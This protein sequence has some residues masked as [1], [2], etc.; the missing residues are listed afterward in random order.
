MSEDIFFWSEADRGKV[1]RVRRGDD[2]RSVP[3][4]D[5]VPREAAAP[6]PE[7]IGRL[8]LR[9]ASAQYGVPVSTLRSWCRRGTI[10][11][12]LVEPGPRWMV[13]PVSVER[14]AANRRGAGAPRARGGAAPGGGMLVPRDAWDR[15]IGQLTNLHETGQ[16]LAEAR[17]RAARAETEAAFLRERLAE[18]RSER[19]DWRERAE[20]RDTEPHR[21]RP[22]VF[23]RIF[24]RRE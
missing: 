14:H 15:L 16:H 22:G 20:H 5:H 18:L 12:S 8:T 6:S 11:G 4:A 24:G 2:R 21:L 7:E 3:S 10:A 19:D 1:R 23:R 9:E 17:E 13:D